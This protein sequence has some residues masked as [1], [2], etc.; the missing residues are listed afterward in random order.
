[1]YLFIFVGYIY[2]AI[3]DATRVIEFVLVSVS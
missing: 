2:D 1:M 3:R